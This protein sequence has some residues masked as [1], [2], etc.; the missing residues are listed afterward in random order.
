MAPAT[1]TKKARK[2]SDTNEDAKELSVLLEK[3]MQQPGVKEVMEVYGDWA[4]TNE[5]STTFQA[6]QYPYPPN[7]V[8]SSSEPV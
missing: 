3:A 7:T 6:Y 2:S 5:V 1:K 8:S 4:K